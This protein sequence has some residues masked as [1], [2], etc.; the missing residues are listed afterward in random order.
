MDMRLKIKKVGRNTFGTYSC[1][2]KNSLGDTDGTI[3]LYCKFIYIVEIYFKSRANFYI[4]PKTLYK[5]QVL[6]IKYKV[7][8][9]IYTMFYHKEID[10]ICL[11][12]I[13]R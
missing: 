12:Y 11:A 7:K 9:I 8:Y 3:K 10:Q 5:V 13:I 4:N 6:F 2:S 1:I